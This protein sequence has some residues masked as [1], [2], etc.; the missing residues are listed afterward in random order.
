MSSLKRLLTTLSVFYTI[1]LGAQ[2]TVSFEQL[3]AMA[4][5]AQPCE[6]ER[7]IND[8]VAE[9]G[10][11]GRYT[12]VTEDLFIEGF[13]IT[14]PRAHNID[15][16]AQKH[17][18]TTSAAPSTHGIYIE[19]LDGKY[20]LRLYFRDSKTFDSLKRW[21]RAVLNLKGTVLC[22]EGNSY[23]IHDI[24]PE[25]IV[26]VEPCQQKDIPVKRLSI[27]RLTDDDLFTYV[28]LKDC[29]FVFKDGSY[30]NIYEKYGKPGIDVKGI[31]HNSVMDGWASVMCDRNGQNVYFMMAT[32]TPWRRSG[33]GVPQGNGE[34]SGIL[35]DTYM[36]RYGKLHSYGLRVQSEEEMLLAWK[37][38]S[39]YNVIA[40]WNWNDGNKTFR[41]DAASVSTAG[42]MTVAADQGHGFLYVDAP[43]AVLSRSKDFNNPVAASEKTYESDPSVRGA[44]GAVDRGAMKIVTE[45]RN[46]WNWDYNCGNSVVLNVSTEGLSG[47]V[48]YVAFTFA[49]GGQQAK[50]SSWFPTDWCVEYSTDGMSYSKADV[51]DMKL[52]SLPWIYGH[53]NVGDIDSY[54]TS[55]EAGLGFTEHFVPLPKELLGQRN[56]IIRI[57]PSRRVVASLAETEQCRGFLT[58]DLKGKAIV[59][60]G[61]IKIGYR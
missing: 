14:E 51:P 29:E 25:G 1:A 39:A 61:T 16:G 43:H 22:R 13:V 4:D 46:W 52:R 26:R 19:S 21:H 42:T 56:V 44:F 6:I 35:V 18:Y 3:R 50:S 38:R 57:S 10:M 2:Q 9:P 28:T 33:K 8:V 48:L 20:G 30:I 40:E 11:T 54:S 59:H 31:A 24:T 53:K 60:F 12:H 5:A 36:P 17:F 45:G 34:I 49:G 23:I 55:Y 7:C 58:Q 15:L 27:S 47:E 41:T 37:G 32:P